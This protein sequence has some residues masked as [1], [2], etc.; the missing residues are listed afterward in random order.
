MLLMAAGLLYILDMVHHGFILSE[1]LLDEIQITA[2]RGS[3]RSA[4]ENTM[5]AIQA[6]MEEMAD[7]VELDV[8]LTMDDVIVLGHDATLKRVAGVN[9]TIASLTWAEL[10]G[11]EVGS[12]F[13]PEFCRGENPAA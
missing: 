9:R 3:S 11:L 2:H 10:E 5:A 4:P 8:Q 7:C 1:G 13:S 6:A 12:W